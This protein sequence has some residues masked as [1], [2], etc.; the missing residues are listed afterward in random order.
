MDPLKMYF[1]L[2]IGI[3][4]CYVSLPECNLPSADLTITTIWGWLPNRPGSFAARSS[5]KNA[6]K[7][8]GILKGYFK[9][10]YTM[11]DSHLFWRFWSDLAIEK[12]IINISTLVIPFQV[13]ICESTKKLPWYFPL[14]AGRCA[15]GQF[16][17]LPGAREK[18]SILRCLANLWT[19]SSPVAAPKD[20]NIYLHWL[21]C[22]VNVGKYSNPME[23]YYGIGEEFWKSWMMQKQILAKYSIVPVKATGAIR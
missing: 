19:E 6:K 8:K 3:F 2:K 14:I 21:R 4:H 10:T 16:H 13:G 23:D 20:W 15:S 9:I 17:V 5:L 22:M 7:N 12:K 11:E 18:P 1:L